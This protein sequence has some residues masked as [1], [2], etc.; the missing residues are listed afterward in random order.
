M[1][2]HA[3]AL[4]HAAPQVSQ[5]A[6][7]EAFEANVV[8]SLFQGAAG[9]DYENSLE[10]AVEALKPKLAEVSKICPGFGG[11]WQGGEASRGWD[12]NVRAP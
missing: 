5:L 10:A 9:D 1:H 4:Q 3:H 7:A 8:E 12:V 11:H 6:G 2:A